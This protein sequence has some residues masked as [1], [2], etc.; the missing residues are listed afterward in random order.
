VST[1]ATIS[2]R[3]QVI[4]SPVLSSFMTY[5]RVC[6]KNRKGVTTGARTAY[7][8]ISPVFSPVLSVIRA[9]RSLVF[10]VCPFVLY[11]LA[12]VLSVFRYIS[13]DYAFGMFKLVLH[14]TSD[15]DVR[16]VPYQHI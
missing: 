10:F 11:P 4:F 8:S 14:C 1:F 9:A 16:F 12:I 7:P 15:D 3:G 6:N 5:H 13:S 2:W